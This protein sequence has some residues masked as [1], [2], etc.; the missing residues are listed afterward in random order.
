VPQDGRVG[1][2]V[3]PPALPVLSNEDGRGLTPFH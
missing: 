3:P 2:A 1:V